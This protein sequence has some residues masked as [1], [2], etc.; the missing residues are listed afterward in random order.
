MVVSPQFWEWFNVWLAQFLKSLYHEI[1]MVAIRGNNSY[2]NLPHGCGYP[3]GQQTIDISQNLQTSL[4]MPHA[5]AHTVAAP[6]HHLAAPHTAPVGNLNHLGHNQQRTNRMNPT[7]NH[8]NHVTPDHQ[9]QKH[10]NQMNHVN[11]L[12]S[13]SQIRH[14]NYNQG[15]TRSQ[16]HNGHKLNSNMTHVGHMNHPNHGMQLNHSQMAHKQV[17]SPAKQQPNLHSKVN[18]PSQ[19]RVGSQSMSIPG[20]G[21]ECYHPGG[22]AGPSYMTGGNAAAPA[23]TM[24]APSTPQPSAPPQPEMTKNNM[25]HNYVSPPNAT[26][27]ARPQYSNFQYRAAQHS[28]RPATH[29]RQQQPY[30]PGSAGTAG[31]PVMYH[32]TLLFP[33]AHMSIPQGYQPR[34]TNPGYY[35]YMSYVY[36]NTNPSHASPLTY[37]PDYYNGQGVGSNAARP[38]GPLVPPAHPPQQQ[39]HMTLPGMRIPPAKRTS[40]RVPIINPVTRQDIFSEDLFAT[41]NVSENSS[42]RQTPLADNSQSIVEEFTRMV[43]KAANEPS[44]G[45]TAKTNHVPKC[46]EVPAMASPEQPQNAINSNNNVKSEVVNDN[47]GS[48]VEVDTPIV[49]AISDSPVIVPKLTNTKHQKISENT[50]VIDNKQKPKAKKPNVPHNETD[51]QSDVVVLTTDMLPPQPQRIREPRV[52]PSEEKEKPQEESNTNGPICNN[53]PEPVN[54]SHIVESKLVRQ[55][56]VKQETRFETETETYK[57]VELIVNTEETFPILQTPTASQLLSSIE[58]VAQEYVSRPETP[59]EENSVCLAQAKLTQSI[60]SAARNNLECVMKDIN[61]NNASS[62]PDTAN[63]NITEIAETV[64]EDMN[65]NE[66]PTKNSKK[67]QKNVTVEVNKNSGTEP[68]AKE[69]CTNGRDETD[70]LNV[71]ESD[72]IPLSEPVTPEPTKP[73]VPVFTLK[74]KYSED[75][76]SPFNPNGKKTYDITLLKQMRDDPL[77]KN[78]PNSPLL[79]SC[80]LLRTVQIDTIMSFNHIHRPANDSLFP[81]FLKTMSPGNMRSPILRDNKKDTRNVGAP[82]GKG[83]M[84]LNSP[85][86]NSGGRNIYISLREE[87][88]LNESKDAWKPTRLKKESL[89]EQE[90]KTQELYK[91]FRG[92]LNKLTPQKFDT[93]VDK[94]KSLEIDTQERLEGVIDLVF[95]KAIDEPNFSEAYAAMCNKLSTLKVPSTNSPEQCVNFR[96]MIISKC[97]NQFIKEKT[98]EHVLKLEAEI[99][100]SNDA[101]KKRELHLQLAEV[102]RRIRMRSV[103]N[104]RFIG[105][106]YKLKILISKIMVYCMNYLIDKPEEEKLECLCKLL[107]TIG[108]QVEGEVKDQLDTIMDKM[109]DIVNDRKSNKISSRVRFMIQDVIELRRRKWVAKNVIDSQP[110]MMDQI[111][112]EAEQRQRHIELMNSPI[113]GGFRRDDSGSG[114]K[115]GGEGRRQG[116]NFM[117]NTWKTTA[118]RTSYVVDTTKLKAMPPQ[119]NLSTIKLAPHNIAW[120]Q[121]SGAK[122]QAV[123]P[124]KNMYSILENVQVD[125]TTLR[126]NKELTPAAYQ[127]SKSIERSTFNTRSDFIG[128]NPTGG[129]SGSTG[130]VRPAST[131]SPSLQSEAP[132][133]PAQPL[134]PPAVQEP[135]PEDRRK[136]IKQLV[137]LCIMN[138]DNN[139]LAEEIKLFGPQ[140]HAAVITEILN[141]ALEKNAKDICI[142]AKSVM[143]VV[144]CGA[145]S[146]DNLMT[147]MAEIFE[148]GPDL[149]IDIPMLYSYL[150]KFVA[151]HIEKKHVTFDQVH[152]AS[153]SLIAV[154]HGHLLLK[155]VIAELKESMGK[156]FTKTKWLE[157]GLQ[158]QQWMNSDMIPKW[159]SDNHFE[160]L[161]SSDD[162]E[163]CIEDT[164]RIM[165]PCETQS[166]LLQLMNS[167]ESCDCL[168]GWVKDNIGASTGEEWFLRCLTQAICEHALFG[169]E[170]TPTPHLSHD[171]MNKYSPLIGDY[172]DSQAQRE[173]AC[174]FGI[175]QLIHRLEH[176]QG[177]SLDIF[178][179]L[180]EQYV[181]SV[182]GFIAWETSEMEPEGK[183]VMLKALTSFFTSIREADIEDSCSEA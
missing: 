124:V 27:T 139:E 34:S 153:H 127:Q 150:G 58:K 71:V 114:R 6:R 89:N 85:S 51:K 42:E 125:P 9:S 52:K 182:D 39:S 17:Q 61:L 57:Q 45:E 33:T 176:P 123:A 16:T 46:N 67:K 2:G 37:S 60:A 110:K 11:H 159:M 120:N 134:P 83:S 140:Y 151:P 136:F 163:I 91:K 62:D 13:M 177:L 157:S 143:H 175:Q 135:L 41:E 132:P 55:N 144:S 131:P 29:N 66:K 156:T 162:S 126:G 142:L 103:G 180:H 106:L 28:T 50:I 128:L 173:A 65:K 63:G 179:Y 74:H 3:G 141:V 101:A 97:Q 121:G 105:E 12:K 1:K 146:R 78:K 49:S 70:N 161:E 84:K 82:P 98:D 90:L 56:E 75:Q 4:N 112:K 44:S 116:N 43:S 54:T 88:K 113:G 170:R 104:V 64:K 15:T 148:C 145:I 47:I 172:G 102:Q 96:A 35:P 48:D 72:V 79:E 154:D 174:L 76:W 160:F 133:M 147:G 117:D 8:V 167:D 69:T 99:A 92:I 119:K 168:R 178:Q 107:T 115:R 87:V 95:E 59:E 181:I 68:S 36:P 18:R 23:P 94:V 5:V 30:M 152:K 81:T 183:A 111:Q 21:A 22:A 20:S 14:S 40:R 53:Q 155:A 38:P 171:R 32:P 31:G 158:L 122:P 164:K 118:T 80:N 169:P 25:G 24:R 10:I 26:A 166:K 19:Y 137:D 138:L 149:Y 93:L 108:E 109:Q 7:V 77:C 86:S 130:G 129:R 73:A 165:T 100:E